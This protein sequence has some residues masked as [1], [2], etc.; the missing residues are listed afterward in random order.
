[1]EDETS[2]IAKKIKK[3]YPHIKLIIGGPHI[4]TLP[5]SLDAIFDYAILGQGEE[6]LYKLLTFLN[7][8]HE[9]Q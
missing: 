5:E 2:E 9:Q 4:T 7:Q 6:R 8:N 3:M 1:M